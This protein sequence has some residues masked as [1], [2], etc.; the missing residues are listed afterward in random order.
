MR[1][2]PT[3]MTGTDS[4]D[5]PSCIV[6]MAFTPY[7]CFALG[8]EPF[9]PPFLCYPIIPQP[10]RYFKQNLAYAF[11]QQKKQGENSCFF[12]SHF[13]FAF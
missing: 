13:R 7:F 2:Q 8:A 6:F 9:T 10:A 11:L 3:A 12:I 4:P 1:M 5:F